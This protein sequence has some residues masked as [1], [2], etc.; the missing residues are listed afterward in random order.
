M[1]K[2]I[3]VELGA[4]SYDIHAGADLLGSCGGVCRKLKLGS[5]CLIVSDSNVAPLYAHVIRDSLTDAGFQPSIF[6]VP[7]GEESKDSLTL[8]LIYDEALAHALDRKSFIVA[9]GGGVIGDLAG[10]AAASFLRGIRFVQVP[11]SLMAM[12]DSSV[13][14]KTGINLPQ[15]KNL[16]GAFHQ[17]SAVLADLV[18]LSTLPDREFISGLSEVMKY[19]VIQDAEFFAFLE[20]KA[21]KILARDPETLEQVVTRCC[22]CKA[23]VVGLD[24]RESGLRA[25]LNFGHTLAHAVEQVAGYGKFLHG[26]AVAIGMAYAAILSVSAAGLPGEAA[27]RIIN[28]LGKFGLPVSVNGLSWN[29][30]RKAMQADKKNTGGAVCFV[31]AREIGRVEPGIEVK[32]DLLEEVWNVISQ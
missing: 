31:L 14:G 30:V 26:E 8:S 7:A 22:K 17:P 1:S 5:R 27:E 28:L 23:E 16:V 9:L 10:Y 6:I 19:G 15:G 4:R 29:A 20:K 2:V 11:T 25:I 18:T 3:R 13:G 32:E 12:V 21:G 24:E